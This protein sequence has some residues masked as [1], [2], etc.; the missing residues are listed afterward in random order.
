M[1]FQRLSY[2][3]VAHEPFGQ[4]MLVP[5]GSRSLVFA[6][7]VGLTDDFELGSW[8]APFINKLLM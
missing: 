1:L 2:S 4:I 5:S 8:D 3:A 7:N 6:S